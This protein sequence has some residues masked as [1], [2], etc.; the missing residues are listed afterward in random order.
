MKCIPNCRVLEE[1]PMDHRWTK[2]RFRGWNYMHCHN[3]LVWSILGTNQGRPTQPTVKSNKYG[4]QNGI[5]A[6]TYFFKLKNIGIENLICAMV[7]R[8]E[9][10]QQ[11]SEKNKE[12]CTMSAEICWKN[13]AHKRRLPALAHIHIIPGQTYSNKC[14]DTK[15]GRA[16]YEQA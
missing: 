15:T 2:V 6:H 5:I 3:G 10:R 7:V 16:G 11:A 9:Q 4:N 8:L 14:N 12:C 13:V 1:I